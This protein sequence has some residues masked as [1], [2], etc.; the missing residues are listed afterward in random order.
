MQR[1]M[2]QR[3]TNT[4]QYHLYVDYKKPELIGTV[5]RWLR[6]FRGKGEMLVKVYKLSIIIQVNSGDLMHI[7]VITV[8][9]TC[10]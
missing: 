1:E 4:A 3:Q 8:N 7:M 9:T 5:E 2:R 6:G 10:T